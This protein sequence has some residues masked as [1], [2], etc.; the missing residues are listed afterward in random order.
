M[1]QK[2]SKFAGILRSHQ[3]EPKPDETPATEASSVEPRRATAQKAAAA[4]AKRPRGRPGGQ[5]KRIN[6]N[7]AQVTAYIPAELH[8]QTKINLLRQPKKLEFSELVEDLLSTWNRKQG[9][10]NS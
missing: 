7:Y 8:T 10:A 3:E 1:S 5:G 2:Q 6:P 4:P 9:D